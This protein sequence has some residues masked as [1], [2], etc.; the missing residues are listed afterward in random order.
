[1]KHQPKIGFSVEHPGIILWE[2]YL[3]PLGVS[4][5]QFARDIGI[6]YPRANEVLNGRRSITPDTALRLSYYLGTTAE[7]WV[8]WQALYE[9]QAVEKAHGTEYKRIARLA[10]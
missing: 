10:A 4:Q 9:L 6:S 7:F 5:S 3:Q 2:E 8:N 1:M